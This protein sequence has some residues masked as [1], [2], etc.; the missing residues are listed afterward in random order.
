MDLDIAQQHVWQAVFALGAVAAVGAAFV[1]FVRLR[2]NNVRLATALDNM[3]QGLC[4]Y[5]AAER[6]V[7]CNERYIA[8]YGLDPARVKPGCTFT[9]VLNH[10]IALG[11]LS[12]DA[13]EYR[14]ALLAEIARG[15]TMSRNIGNGSRI[16]SVVNRPMPGGGWVGTHEDIT[17]RQRAERE[18]EEMAVQ[19]TRREAIESAIAG[20]NAR[21]ETVLR[22]LSEGAGAMQHTAASLL[23]STGQTTQRAEGAVSASREVSSN[24]AVA[25]SAAGELSASISEIAR[26]LTATAE[27]VRAAVAEAETTNGQI[28]SLADASQQ[29]GDV[30]KLIRDIADQTNLLALNATIEAAR[31]G[32]AGRGF[33]VVA[34]EVKTLAVQTAKATEQI[35]SQ[36]Q[37]VQA[38]AL[39]SVDAIHG[40]AERMREI[41]SYTSGVACAVQQQIGRHRGDFAQRQQRRPGHRARGRRPGGGGGRRHRHPRLGRNRPRHRPDRRERGRRT[42][43]R[44]R[45]FSS[46]GRGLSLPARRI[47]GAGANSGDASPTLPPHRLT[48]RPAAPRAP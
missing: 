25:A 24:V 8:M 31:A 39:G 34:A 21:V 48:C 6:L 40:I 2:R 28:A 13:Q 7:I 44:G 15:Q 27:V 9:E 35:A 36:I 22:A 29:I 17:D 38:C 18:R 19:E 32:D 47:P 26:Q 45:G 16:V 41:S 14:R 5:D 12:G 46:Q 37:A 1:R 10:R 33:A 3:S 11:N 42:A 43:R 30:V 23:A 4:M 20:F